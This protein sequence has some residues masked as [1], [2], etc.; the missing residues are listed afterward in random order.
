MVLK[1]MQKRRTARGVSA[2]RPQG[3]TRP[4]PRCVYTVS[5]AI[6]WAARGAAR[7]GPVTLARAVWP[8]LV[9]LCCVSGVWG[10]APSQ[11]GQQLPVA[12]ELSETTPRLVIEAGGHTAIIRALLFTADGRELISVSD[13]KTVRVWSVTPDGRRASLQRTLRGA[14]DDG[15]GGSLYAASL[16]P[17][18][19]QG[20]QQWLA[21]G[22][23]L[24]GTSDADRYA[25]RLHDYA[26]GEVVAL[27]RGHR[28]KVFALAFA[29]TGTWLASAGKDQTIRL[30]DLA[31]LRGNQFAGTPLVLTGHTDHV[32]D[33]A[34]SP[35]GHRLASAAYDT[36][37]GL[38][39]TERLAQGQAVLLARLHGHTKQVHTVAFHP[40]GQTL[41]SGGLDQ[42]IRLWQV[43]D[44]AP[45]GV[46]AQAAH[47]IAALSFAPDGRML[48]AGR[49]GGSDMPKRLTLYA[50]PSGV[51]QRAFIEHQNI[52]L[53]TAFHPS[54][55]WVA[56]GGGNEKEVILWDVA[57]GQGLARLQG[58]GTTI[59]AVGFAADGSA[60]SWGQTYAYT[61]DNNRGP[62]E[63]HF[64]LAQLTRRRGSV[65]QPVRASE[66]LGDLSLTPERGGPFHYTSRLHI[67]RRGKHLG[68]IE[69]GARDG[70]Q[71]TA[72]TLTPDGNSVLSGGFHGVLTL[73]ALDG[74]LRTRFVGHTG[75]IKT[76]AVSA[77]GRWA[78]SGASDQ[79]INLWS[80]ASPPAAGGT[81]I[82][83]TLRLFPTTD[84]AW[85]AWTPHGY[86]AASERGAS[87]S[88]V[89]YSVN[90]GMDK[91][92]RHV[93][94][95]QM[96]EAL[97]RPDLVL[98]A[99]QRPLPPTVPAPP[100][101]GSVPAPVQ[102]VTG[103]LQGGPPPRVTFVSP[104]NSMTVAESHIDVRI[105]LS[106]QGGG[107]GKVLWKINDTLVS[108]HTAT[109]L[110]IPA[111]PRGVTVGVDTTGAT[112]V[113][114]ATPQG[115]AF[116]LSK[117]LLLSPGTNLLEVTAY[118]QRNEVESRV[119][120]LALTRVDPSPQAVAPRPTA[121]ASGS[122]V[123][124]PK[125]YVVAVGINQYRPGTVPFL[126]Y[127]VAD[128]QALVQALR[129]GGKTLFDTVT[130][131]EVLDTQ[132]TRQ[133]ITT[134]LDT[135]AAQAQPQD[136]FVLSLAG[137]GVVLDGVYH[138]LPYDL[139]GIDVE[140]IRR[141]AITQSD[142]Q[143]WLARIQARQSV[144][145]LDT[146]QSG[147][148]PVL[149]ASLQTM[150]EQV[151]VDKLTRAT[152]RAI[153]AA[154]TATQAAVEGY[155]GHGLFTYA[156]LEALRT[157]KNKDGQIRIYDIAAY[158]QDRVPA[159]AQ[160]LFGVEQTPVTR[161]DGRN[162]ALSMVHARR[163]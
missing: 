41:A 134:A 106:D 137:H 17:P 158:V 9:L 27:L 135:V 45:R 163:E 111:Q 49:L 141:S 31:Q 146:C 68:T 33:L 72:Y 62:L 150:A 112:G 66:R 64:D 87:A 101:G 116:M 39:N 4:K 124:P 133:G 125:L 59:W 114:A 36:T 96:Y 89:G 86:F 37:V 140:A 67:Q 14:F 55:Q 142:L 132:A 42:S 65:A 75:E 102:T 147:D 145:L 40:E 107:I 122:I 128:A 123:A 74:S 34:W 2:A 144:V 16:S 100:Q 12:P 152:G 7:C 28:D 79:T 57:T 127:A 155:E 108:E 53:A 15:E 76:V 35:T 26:T 5:R 130:A 160:Q 143:Q 92:A 50:Y 61:N 46:L 154:T 113:P 103:V 118:N 56:S 3:S 161:M 109:D 97:Y 22:G 84:G 18:D 10:A 94:L 88:L 81:D 6:A 159:L 8:L 138:F 90:Q 30:W 153:I 149:R 51:E 156:V 80:L 148:L 110:E 93:A 52:V 54:G 136:V 131:V 117:R 19:T 73:H 105:A 23:V 83:P 91:L 11:S 60:F 71:H 29:P 58:R 25:I 85:V 77:D 63:H 24:P 162:F 139:T 157:V 70:Y 99:L 121:P 82:G 129:Q 151:A 47:E 21:V 13:D 104:A 1:G 43:Q 95:D 69:R 115:T 126:R 44:G 20:R 120:T 32:Y 48:L 78:L 38:W 119:H 98:A